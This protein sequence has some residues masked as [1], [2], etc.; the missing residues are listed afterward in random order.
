LPRRVK[1]TRESVGESLTKDSP[2]LLRRQANRITF[3]KFGRKEKLERPRGDNR[4][5]EKNIYEEAE[6]WVF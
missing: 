2:G 3:P 1:G 5:E 6:G 4:K